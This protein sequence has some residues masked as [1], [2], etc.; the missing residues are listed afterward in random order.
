MPDLVVTDLTVEYSSGGYVVRPLNER[1][2]SAPDGQLV[3]LLGPSGCGKTTLLSCLAGLLTP[4][5]GSIR[6]G[7]REV[8][9]LSAKE[10]GEYRRREVG[11]V[12]QAFNL[13][14][15][16]SALGNVMV[17]MTLAGIG[18]RAARARAE[19]L[20]ERV[21]LADRMG[22]RPPAMSGGQQQRV[23][24]ARALVHDPPLVLADEPTAHLDYLQVEGVLRLLRELATPGRI[25]V[26][27]THDD[28]VTN[29][30][31]AVVDLAPTAAAADAAPHRRTLVAGEVLFHQGD[32]G[33]YVYVVESGA[34][35]I[36]HELFG[37]G[38]EH[39]DVLGRG[40]YFGELAL[41]LSLPRSASVRATEDAVVVG[42]GLHAFRQA[43][44][45]LADPTRLRD[46][47]S[48]A[49]EA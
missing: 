17:P 35:E 30:A 22:H 48:A 9:G 13:L 49:V 8:V 5:S 32:P 15:S 26:V 37:G 40:R 34:V 27:A 25:V 44:P 7:E 6:L 23:A 4:T 21:G 1:S 38:E 36:Y 16:L 29:I 10:L 20:L 12:F 47:G 19:E 14:P 28:R 31:D 2:V 24:I 45:A 11:V 41:V 33:D 46:T 18:R 3:V 39:I 42:Y 43:Y